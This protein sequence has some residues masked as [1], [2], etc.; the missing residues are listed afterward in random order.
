MCNVFLESIEELF[1]KKKIR[2]SFVV[3]N[4]PNHT[5]KALRRIEKDLKR[6]H[7]KHQ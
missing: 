5:D 4:N 6:Q 3:V 7:K 1:Q 2:N